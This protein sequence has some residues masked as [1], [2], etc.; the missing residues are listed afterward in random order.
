MST[1]LDE[2]WAEGLQIRFVL[3]EIIA[4][5][6][7]E[8]QSLLIAQTETY[9]RALFLDG[10]LQST[11][12][13]E[14]L[15][16][17][18]LVH[19]AMIVHGDV[20]RVLVGGAGEG[21]SLREVLRHPGVQEVLAVDLDPGVVEACREHLPA[22]SDGAFDDPRVRLRFEDVQQTLARDEGPWD[23]V[24]LD[25]TDPVEDGP[26]VD[27]FTTRF[28]GTVADRLAEGGIVVLQSG[29]LDPYDLG[30]ARTVQTTLGE[31][32]PWVHPMVIH[33]PSFHCIWSLTLAG[34]RPHALVPDDLEARVA[35]LPTERLGAYSAGVHRGLMELPPWVRKGLDEPGRVLSGRDEERLV[36]FRRDSDP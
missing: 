30:F 1:I 4:Q 36:T 23:L 10:L 5:R 34:L 6:T 24:L 8:L 31:V 21:A 7:T 12:A 9:G 3:E 26:A 17:E 35:R 2:P 19:P 32:F 16:H 18:P 13:D 14:A 15:Y 29:E 25:I 27:L 22:W 20:R 33:V 28:F 11:E